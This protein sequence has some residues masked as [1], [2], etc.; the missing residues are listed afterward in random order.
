MKNINAKDEIKE[1][2]YNMMKK[3]DKYPFKVTDITKKANINRS[4]FY[5]HYNNVDM[6]LED[7]YNDFFVSMNNMGLNPWKPNEEIY[8][9]TLLQALKELRT[10][11]DEFLVLTNKEYFQYYLKFAYDYYTKDIKKYND[12]P[13]DR[14]ANIFQFF[15]YY[16]VIISWIKDGFPVKEE[17]LAHY[18]TTRFISRDI[19]KID[20]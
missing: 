10:R 20:H 8:Y 5:F 7:I 17:E 16:N 11:S 18:L 14:Y 4:T 15:G 2:V 13:I 19:Q 6:V 9:A 1:T 3:S 12:E